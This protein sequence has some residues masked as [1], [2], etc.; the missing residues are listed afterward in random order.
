MP[1]GA[2]VWHDLTVPD[3]ENIKEFYSHVIGWETKPHPMCDDFN[4]IIPETG[5]TIA[6]ICHARGVNAGI[7]PQWLIYV[8]VD[9]VLESIE[10]CKELGGTVA[11]GPRSIGTHNF[12]V[13]QDPAGA[14]VGLIETVKTT[15]TLEA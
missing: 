7:P 4:A 2:I 3:A 12:C 1:T 15:E 13:I 11:Y 10:R 9:N 6:G 8:E 14:V 5:E